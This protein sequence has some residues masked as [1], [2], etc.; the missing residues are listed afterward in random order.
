VKI[1]AVDA[2]NSRV[3]WGFTDRGFTDR[4]F[5]DRGFTDRG[6]SEH[7]QWQALGAA[8]IGDLEQGIGKAWEDLGTPDR[9]AVA[10]VAGPGV[11]SD[12]AGRMGHWAITPVWLQATAEACG[13]KN[14]YTR[15]AQLGV[16]R[17]AALVAARARH[18]AASLVVLAGTATTIDFLD[19]SGVF[20]GGMILPGARLMKQALHHHTAGLPLA[21]GDYL[22]RPRSTED[23]IET[24]CRIAQVAAIE[25]AYRELPPGAASIV[26]GGAAGELLALLDFRAVAVE[27]LVLEGVVMLGQ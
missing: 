12:L 24:G 22:A 21:Q 6:L 23:A 1:L 9:I 27:H 19:A 18:T 2:G 20:C 5:T 7:G 13:V 10:N 8:A 15:A 17:W 4:G 14:A 16:D 25:R 3:K 11:A 26:S